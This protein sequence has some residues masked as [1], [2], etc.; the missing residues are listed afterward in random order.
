MASLQLDGFDIIVSHG[1]QLGSPTPAQ[2]HEAFPDAEIILFG[3]THKPLLELVDRTV[4]V[5]NPGSAGPRRFEL[6]VTVGILELESGIPPRGR[7]VP[8]GEQGAQSST[9]GA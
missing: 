1:D 7:I 6:P 8:L 2:L 4:T 9:P 5:M 3:H